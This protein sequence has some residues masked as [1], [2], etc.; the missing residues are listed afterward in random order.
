MAE[1]IDILEDIRPC[2]FQNC[3]MQIHSFVVGNVSKTFPIGAQKELEVA[4]QD[5]EVPQI[6]QIAVLGGGYGTFWC[7]D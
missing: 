7:F 5:L 4:R 1:S 6:S 2:C 3:G